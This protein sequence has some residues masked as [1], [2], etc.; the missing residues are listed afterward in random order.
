M[1]RAYDRVTER[2]DQMAH[3]SGLGAWERSSRVNR[4]REAK[5]LWNAIPMTVVGVGGLVLCVVFGG[6]GPMWILMALLAL[7]GV[8]GI[9]LCFAAYRLL[10]AGRLLLHRFEHGF[11]IERQH[12]GMVGATYENTRAEIIEF[13]EPGDSTSNPT[14]H[15]AVLFRF[16]EGTVLSV[17]EPEYGTPDALVE[18]AERCATNERKLLSYLDAQRAVTVGRGIL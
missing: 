16:S 15:I 9:G 14:P 5:V 17:E 12:S 11:V 7:I 4:R 3:E 2:A 1:A 10:R 6:R 18:V 13:S 8:I